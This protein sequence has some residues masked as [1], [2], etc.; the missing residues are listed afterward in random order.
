MRF[1]LCSLAGGS[2]EL[3]SV[4]PSAPAEPER[5]HTLASSSSLSL[6][7]KAAVRAFHKTHIYHHGR[8]S[9]RARCDLCFP[10]AES[11]TICRATYLQIEKAYQKQ[12]LFQNAKVRVGKKVTKSKRWYKDVGLGFKTP[13]EA[14]SGTYIG[15]HYIADLR[16]RF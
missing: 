4:G 9:A 5:S 10:H 2:F 11:L 12:H 8:A 6:L 1:I 3:C 15:A 7:K 13:S 16:A 14:I